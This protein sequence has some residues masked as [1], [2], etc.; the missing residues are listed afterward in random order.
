M[1][2]LIIT[3]LIALAV[4]LMLMMF[5]Q[6]LTR[7]VDFFSVRNIYLAGF[8]IYHVSSPIS[9][10][11]DGTY[12][13]FK[14]IDPLGAAKWMLIYTYIYVGVYLFSY[15]RIKI[16][17]W[18]ASKFSS[19]SGEASDSLLTGVSIAMIIAAIATRIIGMQVQPLAAI[20][21]NVSIALAAASCAIVGWIWGGRRF[22]SGRH[23]AGGGGGRNQ[24]RHDAGRILLASAADWHSRRFRLGGLL[25]LGAIHV[26]HQAHLCDG[27]ARARRGCR[28]R[29]VHRRAR[30]H[31]PRRR[32]GHR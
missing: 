14:I 29:G 22:E 10:L 13:G 16:S 32:R 1:Q 9:A 31:P 23:F 15:N 28:H 17:R 30:T 19:G 21:T 8:I 4:G 6:G 27:A 20:S 2:G 3:L 5:A 24:S 25:S 26:A 18:F 7:R 11:Q 12:I